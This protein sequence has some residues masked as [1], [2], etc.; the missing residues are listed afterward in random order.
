[1]SESESAT[2]KDQ[3]IWGHLSLSEAVPRRWRIGNCAFT[4]RVVEDEW[5]FCFEDGL[6]DSVLATVEDSVTTPATVS[7]IRFVT[8]GNDTVDLVPALPDRPVVIRPEAEITVLPGR[9]AQFYFEIPLWL[10]F[11]SHPPKKEVVMLEHPTRALSN[12]WFGDPSAGE[13]CYS[14][15]ASL[16]RGTDGLAHS[17]G[18]AV[19]TLVVRNSSDENL[20][21]RRICVHA[22]NLDLF[23][24][25]GKLWTNEVQVAFKGAAPVSQVQISDQPPESLSGA[26]LLTPRRAPYERRILRR[27]FDF[28]R[29][30][31]GM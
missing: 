18:T 9:W 30:A 21:F 28:L 25:G 10:R 7:W 17:P 23:A 6:E 31:V 27:S 5:H 24:S 29:N 13:L 8:L 15:E 20:G 1:M 11:V 14:L 3:M 19:C 26:T 4:A 16:R 12:I 22:E 2:P